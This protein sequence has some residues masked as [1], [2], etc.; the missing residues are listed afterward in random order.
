MAENHSPS[1]ARLFLVGPRR[2]L[3]ST[4]PWHHINRQA[5]TPAQND[6]SQKYFSGQKA[7]FRLL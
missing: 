7:F 4:P 2:W 1:V 6:K 3:G 5:I